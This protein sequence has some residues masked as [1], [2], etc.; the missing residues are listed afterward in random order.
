MK[1]ITVKKSAKKKVFALVGIFILVFAI[2]K[3]ILY[4]AD[5]FDHRIYYVGITA[6]VGIATLLFVIFFFM[7]GMTMSPAPT[8]RENL[9]ADWSEDRKT[10]YLEKEAV[11]KPKARKLLYVFLPM[12]VTILVNYFEIYLEELIRKIS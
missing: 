11:R 10:E 5:K 8:P 12:V 2:Y 7:N 4:F 6:Y 3:A 9:P 1:K